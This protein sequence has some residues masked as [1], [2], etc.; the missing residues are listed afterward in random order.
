MSAHSDLL[1]ELVARFNQ[2]QPIDVA[3][4]F[5]PNFQLDQPGGENRI[6]L[7]GAQSMI[8]SLYRLGDSVQLHIVAMIEQGDYLAVRWHVE[9]SPEAAGAMIGMYRFESGRIA[10]DWGLAVHAQWRS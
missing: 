1:R 5:A 3:R 7:A 2:R 8:D 4:Y 10:D 9:G 6:G